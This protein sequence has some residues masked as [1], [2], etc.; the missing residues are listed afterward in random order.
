MSIQQENFKQIANAIREKTNS[1]DSI[2]PSEFA[3]KVDEV[4]E[5]GKKAQYDSF[6]DG[7]QI[8]GTRNYY[9]YAF[10]GQG[11]GNTFYPKYN[12]VP[13]NTCN[14]LFREVGY[15]N[16][17][18]RLLECGVTLDTSNVTSLTYSFAYGSITELPK[19]DCSNVGT[20]DSIFRDEKL[21]TLIE[22]L[23]VTE[24]L[25][26]TNP[27]YNCIKLKDITITGVIGESFDIHFS[28]LTKASITSII[29]ALSSNASGKVVTFNKTAKEAAFT[30]AEWASLVSTKTNWT[31]ALAEV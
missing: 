3:V 30:D 31:I 16:L 12:I 20:L 1:T 11:W 18:K 28:P 8:N 5:A 4:F 21:L 7:Y 24:K 13:T 17:R 15:I 19:I 25:K 27:F 2:K 23:V 14:G 10:A 9:A 22:E 29:N 6:W 26:Y